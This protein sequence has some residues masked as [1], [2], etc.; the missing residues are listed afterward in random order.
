MTQPHPRTRVMSLGLLLA[1][2]ALLLWA[3]GRRPAHGYIDIP[4]PSLARLCEDTQAIAVLRVER[5]NLPKRGIVYRKARDLKGSF[6]AH[7]HYFG[8]TF[9]H[10]IRECPNGHILFKP[11]NHMDRDRL[12]L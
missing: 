3:E 8:D 4:V 12:E 2:A 6:P 10:I 9:T 11:H 5:V 7:K 1:V